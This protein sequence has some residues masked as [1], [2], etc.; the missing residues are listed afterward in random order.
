MS[1]FFPRSLAWLGCASIALLSCGCVV[2]P[3]ELADSEVETSGAYRS[4]TGSAPMLPVGRWWDC[5]GD[6]GLNALIRRLD[7][8]NPSLAVALARYDAARAE[9]GLTRA[10]KFPRLRGN[11]SAR[12][13]RDSSSG[14]FVPNELT[15]NEFRAA[16]NLEWEI[17][18]WG[19]VRQEVKAARAEAEAVEADWAAARLS[20]RTE[21]ARNYYQLRHID[22]EIGILRRGLDLREENRRLISARVE[23]GETTDLDLARAETELEA[24][25][26]RLHELERT[27]ATYFNALAALVGETPATFTLPPGGAGGPPSIPAG[28][29]SELLTRRPDIVAADRRMRAAAARIGEVRASYLPRVNLVGI[30]GLSSLELDDLFN[31]S[32]LF[33]EIGPD[34]EIPL[35]NAG[36]FGLDEERA[37]A[38]SDEAVALYRETVLAA[39]REVEDSL[40]GIRY[41]D[42]EIRAHR[43]AA[44]AARRASRL[45][46]TR[47]DGGLV[48]FLDVVD[49]ERTALNESRELVQARAARTL[50]TVRLIQALGG[51]WEVE[52]REGEDLE[53]GA[54]FGSSL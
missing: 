47:Y 10:D 21:L 24:T 37:F 53:L 11:S 27:R 52:M 25:R 22:E 34:I 41:L 43:S 33:G 15:Y 40:S 46:R 19:R 38:E 42:R 31:P 35:Y 17:D 1:N 18:L 45:S 50:E 23:G 39:F 20:L 14:V 13:R 2:D 30:G 4:G 6:E 8:D 3:S 26:A 7:E 54:G 5:F 36:R 51:G 28:L 29:P 32:S 16:L 48:S 49:A 12:R 9:L 44:S